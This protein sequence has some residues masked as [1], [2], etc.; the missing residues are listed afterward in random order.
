MGNE[1]NIYDLSNIRN[2]PNELFSATTYG[3]LGIGAGLS[4]NLGLN[5]KPNQSALAPQK[6]NG[7]DWRN[8][9]TSYDPS[10][11]SKSLMIRNRQQ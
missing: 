6:Q 11:T 8:K 4:V 2:N 1:R 9:R 10:L 5:L 3:G 7:T